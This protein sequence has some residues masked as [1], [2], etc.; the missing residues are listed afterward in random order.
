MP[1]GLGPVR[2]VGVGEGEGLVLAG[3]GVGVGEAAGDGVGV[4]V[5]LCRGVGEGRMFAFRFVLMFGMAFIFG[6]E[7]GP[8]LKLKFE[9]NPKLVLIFTF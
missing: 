2:M 4:G 1:G 3:V 5:L 9:S 7:I 8:A 6:V